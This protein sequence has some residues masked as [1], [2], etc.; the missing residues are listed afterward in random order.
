[1]QARAIAAARAEFKNAATRLRIE[2]VR[3]QIVE[4]AAFS[5][6]FIAL[7]TVASMLAGIGLITDNT[8]VIV[9]SMLVSPIMGPVLG[10]T[11]GTRI[12][13]WPL[14]R[15]SFI[16][17]CL[18]L[19]GCVVIGVLVGIAAGFTDLA[20]N[21]WPT[22]EMEIRGEAQGLLTGIAIAIPSGM[23]VCLSI[24][25]GNTSSL[26]GVAI[27]ASLLP[28]AVNAGVC[29][30]YAIFLKA[31]ALQPPDSMKDAED[32]A[33]IGGISLALTLVNILCIWIAGL[34]MFE[35][36]EV[37]PTQSKNAFWAKDIKVARELNKKKSPP[38]DASVIRRG[39]KS[40]LNR[41]PSDRPVSKVELQPSPR[42]KSATAAPRPYNNLNA[43]FSLE[44]RKKTTS[45]FFNPLFWGIGADKEGGMDGEGTDDGDNVQYV[46]L[47]DMAN[48]LGFNSEEDDDGD[49]G[50]YAPVAAPKPERRRFFF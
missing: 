22:N 48:L 44:Q 31:G 10:L 41:E 38:V 11:F 25:G 12:A 4:Q 9:A 47:E 26:V 6:D 15:T 50:Q 3:E 30:V 29:L 37:A 13:D 8:V 32:F 46:G 7:L 39:L 40:A 17:E 24:L 35:I 16:H 42:R 20:E 23:G 14:V 19:L 34:I 33:K 5:F 28:P 45:S 49:D 2:Q 36:K 21:E 27:S 43:A 1:M 18:A